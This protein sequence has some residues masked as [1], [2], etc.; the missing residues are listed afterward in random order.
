MALSEK[1]QQE[2]IS[3]VGQGS[4]DLELDEQ[5]ALDEEKRVAQVAR[6]VASSL[7]HLRRGGTH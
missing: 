7:G 3:L 4:G 5:F 6:N 2:I 1:R